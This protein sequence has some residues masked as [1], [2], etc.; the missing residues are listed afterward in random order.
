M[1]EKTHLIFYSAG[2]ML[3]VGLGWM[4]RDWLPE[5]LQKRLPRVGLILA[6]KATVRCERT[7]P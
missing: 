7:A 2:G 4:R 3:V 6:Y 1:K 5:S